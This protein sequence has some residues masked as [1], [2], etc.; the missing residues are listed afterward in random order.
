[1]N[2]EMEQSVKAVV[3]HAPQDLRLDEQSGADLE[4]GQVRIRVAFGGICGSDLHYFHDGG[5]GAVRITEPMIL[6]HEVSGVIEELGPGV[7]DLRPGDP[8]AI[9][10]AVDDLSD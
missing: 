1:M 2:A 10:D 7:K 8:V 5:F 3:I 4:R 9:N 6:G